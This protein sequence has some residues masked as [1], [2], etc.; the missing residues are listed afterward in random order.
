MIL[1]LQNIHKAFG[2]NQVLSDASLTVQKG[3]RMG[4]VGVN[5]S[6]KSTLMKIICGQEVADKGVVH[7]KKDMKIGYLAQRGVVTEGQTVYQELANVFLPVREMEMRLR[8]LE[9]SMADTADDEM[10]FIQLCSDYQRLLDAFESENGYGWQSAVM[11]VLSGL[12][13]TYEQHS[14]M[15]DKLSGGELTRLCLGKLLLQRPELLL[16]D[17]PT[18]HLDMEALAWLEKYL[19]DYTGTVLVISHDRYFLDRVCTNVAELLGGTIEQYSGNYS[20]F[21]QKRIQLFESRIKA[22]ELQQ[23]EIARQEAIIARYRMYNREK[24]IR[25]AESR[26]KRLEKIERLKK[27]EQEEFIRFRFDTARRS[28]DDVLVIKGLGKGFGD[29][30]LFSSLDLH[31]RAGDRV[32]LIGPNGVGKTTLMKCLAGDIHPDSG[33]FRLGVNV[34]PGYYDQ[35]QARLDERKTVLDEVW[36]AYPRLDQST[37]RGALGLFLFTGDDVFMPIHTLSGGEKGRVA[38]VKL[39][40]GKHNFLL[41]D[42]PTNHL[43]MDS[44]E[45]LEEALDG[46]TGTILAISHDRYFIN[47]FANKVCVL[48]T[49][50]LTEYAGNY[51]SYLSQLNP[52]GEQ[53]PDAA[54]ITKTMLSKVKRRARA[55]SEQIAEQRERVRILEDSIHTLECKI[56]EYE[57]KLA[58]T[59]TYKDTSAAAAVTR[60]YYAVKANLS[61]L[62]DQWADADEGLQMLL[63]G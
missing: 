37:V 6:G 19:C 5:G 32:A 11:G 44:C 58:N 18:N 28:G 27:P 61:E 51:D 7:A 60:D 48:H 56:L 26:E 43:D 1:S 40:L 39:M 20:A 22:Y 45:V 13:F 33:S 16:L 24:S 34:D 10:L 53:E 57:G 15:A 38:L 21:S 12:G 29:R 36:D 55:T 49:D 4:L 30:V 63:R 41:L 35:H 9:R 42:E 31:L 46:Y 59:D 47:R 8:E 50:G 62:Y 17:E 52:L 2:G 14:L 3:D 23:K 25:A 54:G